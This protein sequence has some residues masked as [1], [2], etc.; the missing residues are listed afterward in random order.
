MEG[1]VAAFGSIPYVN[2]G[3]NKGFFYHLVAELRPENQ[4]HY[5]YFWMNAEQMDE[6]L[7]LT[8]PELK[9]Q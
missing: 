6:I 7:S 8:G 3:D 9:K 5:Q 4:C 1:E 2:K